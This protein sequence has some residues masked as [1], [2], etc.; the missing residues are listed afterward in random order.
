[1]LPLVPHILAAALAVFAQGASAQTPAAPAENAPASV[2]G[3]LNPDT[4]FKGRM[5]GTFGKDIIEVMPGAKR[6][7]V[8]SFRVAFITDNSVSAQVRGSYLPGRDSSGARSSLYVALKG[9]DAKTFQ[10]ITDKA[11][12]RRAAARWWPWT[13]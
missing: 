6:I 3:E 13:R 8:A 10:A 12:A 2:P 11:Y 1:M 7:A 5:G 9:V 4:Y